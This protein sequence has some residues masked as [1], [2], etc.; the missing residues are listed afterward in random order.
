ML[1]TLHAL[2]SGKIAGCSCLNGDSQT[3][4]CRWRQFSIHYSGRH[5]RYRA[6]RGI[7][8]W[9]LASQWSWRRCGQVAKAGTRRGWR[10][11]THFH[12]HGSPV[13]ALDHSGVE[14]VLSK[15]QAHVGKMVQGLISRVT[16]TRES[17][18]NDFADLPRRCG[19]SSLTL[20]AGAGASDPA[21]LSY[22]RGPTRP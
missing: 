17:S 4:V 18:S 9:V 19:R 20:L 1:E 11:H 3:A 8:E 12:Y 13:S 10:R 21:P 2:N 22:V 15:N 16:S 7:V 14:S 5:D 6:N